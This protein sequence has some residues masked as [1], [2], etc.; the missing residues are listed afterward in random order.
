MNGGG[1]GTTHT[2]AGSLSSKPDPQTISAWA[3]TRRGGR[4]D[5]RY[6][7]RLLLPSY[8]IEP[9]SSTPFKQI[10]VL[11]KDLNMRKG[12]MV[13]QGAHA[14][15]GA[16]LRNAIRE[17]SGQ[18]GKITLHLDEEAWGWINGRF[19][20]VCVGVPNLDALLDIENQA[21][22]AGLP[23]VLIQDAGFTE[24]NGTPTWTAAAIGP[25]AS[26]RIDAIT[27]HLALL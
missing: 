8:T 10:I 1:T 9:M 16:L 5:T 25:A 17:P 3:L 23:T 27:G 12:K 15:M 22:L 14:S 11:R 24:F 2:L 26:Q 13:A 7:T 6:L 4:H 21:R 18:G 20:K 19:T